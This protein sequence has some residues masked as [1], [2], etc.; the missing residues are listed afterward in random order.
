MLYALLATALLSLSYFA[1]AALLRAAG[2]DEED[3]VIAGLIFLV[4]WAVVSAPVLWA[5]AALAALLYVAVRAAVVFH[6]TGGTRALA[7]L[8]L[9]R[10]Y[11]AWDRTIGR[12]HR[13]LT[14]AARQEAHR[15]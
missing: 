8:M 7:R 11:L 15:M 6:R 3:A 1:A 13:R 5:W 4:P 2:K 12:L 9:F 10:S 14:R